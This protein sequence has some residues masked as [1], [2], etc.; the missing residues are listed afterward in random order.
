MRILFLVA[1]L[2]IQLVQQVWA[3]DIIQVNAVEKIAQLECIEPLSIRAK[4]IKTDKDRKVTIAQIVSEKYKGKTILVM[5]KAIQRRF[6]RGMLCNNKIVILQQEG[7]K[8]Q[9]Q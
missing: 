4:I 1:V 7:I 6:L 9:K 8:W 3:G 5:N 2:V